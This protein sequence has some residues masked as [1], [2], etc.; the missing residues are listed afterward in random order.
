MRAL[1]PTALWLLLLIAI[2]I[3]LYLFKRQAKT[4]KVSTLVFFQSLAKEH[5]EAA[6]LRKLKKWLSLLL[7]L[8]ALLTLIGALAKIVIAPGGADAQSVV[9]LLDRSASMAAKDGLGENRLQ[10][11]KAQLRARLDALPST[12][13]VALV[14]YDRRTEIIVPKTTDRRA[15]LRGLDTVS[16]RPVP[17]RRADALATAGRIAGLRT[18]AQ[19]WDASDQSTAS[20]ETLS[21]PRRRHRHPHLERPSRRYQYRHHLLPS[22]SHSARA[23]PLRSLRPGRAQLRR[24]RLRRSRTHHPDRCRHPRPPPLRT[25]P[26]ER[27]GLVLPIEGGRG[28]ELTIR[29]SAPGD[30]LALDNSAVAELPESRPV[31]VAWIAEKPDPFVGL[32]LNA[33]A[34]EGRLEIFRGKPGAWPLGDDIDAVLFQGWLPQDDQWDP[35][36]PTIVI[37]PPGTSGPVRAARIKA[38]ALPRTDLREADTSH[39]VLFG[40]S[41]GRAAV[42]QT[43][44]LDTGTV[45]LKPLWLAGNEPL[46]AAGEIAGQR[47]VVMGFSP[48]YSERL[49]LT[50]SFPLLLSN[51]VYWAT[52]PARTTTGIA[53]R[54]GETLALESPGSLTWR[55]LQNGKIISGTLAPATGT[56]AELDRQGLWTTPSGKTGTA[57]LLSDAET[58]LI[59]TTEESAEGETAPPEIAATPAPKRSFLRGQ[60]APFFIAL[61]VLALLIESYLFHRHGVY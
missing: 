22:P 26:G 27:Q 28:Q 61:A 1:A 18:P 43:A 35:N 31:R 32:A 6:W 25:R 37:D 58:Q 41:T 46:L 29:V 24:T 7:A 14:A 51:A 23:R 19:I 20:G 52:E 39:P 48:Q 47:L 17:D 50:A 42:A 59:P 9:I 55:E 4:V 8:I 11:T 40:V 53:K 44:I 57:L 49:P 45:G 34:E 13:P 54:T 10:A 36:I 2:P 5:R 60:L 16:V 30:V 15:L 38:G 3:A 56:L 21:L 12:V 33:L